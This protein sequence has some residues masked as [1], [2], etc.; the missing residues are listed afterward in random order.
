MTWKT[1]L[2]R[3][4]PGILI[5]ILFPGGAH[6]ETVTR[7]VPTPEQIAW[8]QMEIEMFVALDPCTWQGREY[9]DHSTPL[10]QINPAQLDTEQWCE[11]AE[12]FGAK[13][14]LFVAKHTGGFCWWQTDTTTY[15]IKSTPY[16]N[17]RGDVLA[18]IAASCKK[19]GLK[20]AV[21]IYP[22]DDNW[23]AGIGSGGKTKDPAKQEAYNQVLR[24]QWTEALTRYGEVSELWFDGSC[25]VELGDII[26]KYAPKAMV[27][28]GPYT[29]LRWPGNEAGVSPYPAWQTVKKADAV[30][31]VSTAAN[32]DPDGDTW[33]PMEM[34]TTLLDHKWF[35]GPNTDLMMKPLDKLVDV[36]YK[37]V[38]RGGLLLLNSTP[39]TTGRIPESHM[40]RYKEFGEAIRRIYENKK[41][42][43]AGKGRVL[44]LRFAQPTAV[45][46]VI[47]MEDI[48]LGQIVRAYEVDGLIAREW[49]KLAE[50]S[51]I[52]YKKIDVIETVEVEGLR[53]RATKDVGEPVIQSFAAYELKKAGGASDT[54]A[55]ASD[56]AA[57]PK[58][59]AAE[60][61]L[62]QGR[63]VAGWKRVNLTEEW[64]T[65]EVD[66][67]QYIRVPGQYQ[68]E[69][70]KTGGE[71]GG[72]GI[73][74][75][76]A[77]VVIAGTEA[78]RLI[79]PLNREGAGGPGA[80][81]S[82]T[83]A[84]GATAWIIRRTDQVTPD[85]KGRTALRLTLR[86][87]GAG[88]WEGDLV[89]RPI[90]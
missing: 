11:A 7:G 64:R 89:I 67:T 21:Y 47:T 87:T 31:G 12:S 33:L 39:D 53:L 29:T 81:A 23:G 85:A 86:L 65:V 8:H 17:G 40:R 57:G 1:F 76:R 51:S 80:E 63:A 45:N 4:L 73:E 46:H 68:V 3:V 2:R 50:G 18:E 69:L 9:D 54:A 28:Q 37:S 83:N 34:D 36:Y 61:G 49:R 26:K 58:V 70:R 16:K 79:S 24:R 52:G 72:A 55:G 25:V 90:E 20:L 62:R 71:G 88:S 30:S 43:R 27:L 38:G 44:E 6:A 75:R 19:H 22:G 10:S 32:S 15:S 60:P 78:P 35:W 13:Q 14:I 82:G 42:E 74:V 48:R 5:G 84:E 59:G 56:T 77:V 66:L 41:G